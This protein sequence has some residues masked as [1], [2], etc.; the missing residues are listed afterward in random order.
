MAN[1]LKEAF[2]RSWFDAPESVHWAH[3][4]SN[5]VEKEVSES[6]DRAI[7]AWNTRPAAPVDGLETKA[8]VWKTKDAEWRF[9][10]PFFRSVDQWRASDDQFDHEDLCLKSKA[11]AIIA[12]NDE[13]W[14]S[15]YDDFHEEYE[16]VLADNAAKDETIRRQDIALRGA[17]LEVERLKD[18]NAA[19]TARVKA[20]ETQLAEATKIRE[21]AECVVWFD[22][23]GNDDDAV[24]AVAD[25]RA[26]LEGKP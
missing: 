11:E 21:T 12:A 4:M 15:T 13:A 10:E 7:A 20:L 1:E 19:L 2:L 25:L 22:W 26:A 8:Y 24:K 16:K 9:E 17:L 23:S 6:F 3:G 18:D 14:K 5:E